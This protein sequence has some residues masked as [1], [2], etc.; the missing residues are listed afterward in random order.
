MVLH[1]KECAFKPS[2]IMVIQHH[3]KPSLVFFS[4]TNILTAFWT[5]L[6]RLA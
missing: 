6:D 5:A 2:N 1:V 4:A 3:Q